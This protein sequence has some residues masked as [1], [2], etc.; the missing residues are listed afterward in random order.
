MF[1]HFSVVLRVLIVVLLT[2][3]SF[4]ISQEKDV[5]TCSSFGCTPLD[6]EKIQQDAQGFYDRKI[7]SYFS[8]DLNTI[9]NPVYLEAS[10]GLA[11]AL[12]PRV[13]DNCK[14][15]NFGL[16][17]RLRGNKKLI[18]SLTLEGRTFEF[19]PT[20][21]LDILGIR[22]SVKTLAPVYK[23]GNT[24]VEASLEAGLFGSEFAGIIGAH[25]F[26]T[27]SSSV[28]ADATIGLS[29]LGTYAL[30][31]NITYLSKDKI[32]L[33]GT[34]GS[35][36]YMPIFGAVQVGVPYDKNIG[37]QVSLR[38]GTRNNKTCSKNPTVENF[39][40]LGFGISYAF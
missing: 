15:S 34:A 30:R 18:P 16:G 27:I 22:G 39:F 31:T 10:Q 21:E 26:Y 14:A 2:T 29:T 20:L 3:P 40:G 5:N 13:Y 4:L 35:D 38:G 33:Q 11:P 12:D 9:Y 36:S 17:V 8:I 32:T 1:R 24:R 25:G 19:L 37:F 6:P 7:R 23:S 28:F